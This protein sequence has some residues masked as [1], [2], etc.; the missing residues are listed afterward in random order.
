MQNHSPMSLLPLSEI[1]NRRE[2]IEGKVGGNIGVLR[3]KTS[4]VCE[5]TLYFFRLGL[6]LGWPSIP[7]PTI[8]Q[9]KTS[10]SNFP[11]AQFARAQYAVAQF[12]QGPICCKKHFRGPNYRWK[13]PA[14]LPRIWNDRSKIF[15]W[16]ACKC[17]IPMSIR[18]IL[19]VSSY[20]Q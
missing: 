11:G 6:G 17:N 20:P 8:C 9:T 13:T 2:R 14:R 4:P 3:G 7:E 16:D 1:F 5:T 10:G 19:V 12:S 18:P 15:S